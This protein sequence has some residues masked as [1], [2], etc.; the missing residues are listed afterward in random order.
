M[1]TRQAAA[2]LC[3]A[4]ILAACDR[5]SSDAD[6]TDWA[7]YMRGS[8]SGPC[9]VAEGRGTQTRWIFNDEVF[10]QIVT[11]S[12]N[13]NCTGPSQIETTTGGVSAAGDNPRAPAALDLFP[14]TTSVLPT[15]AEAAQALNDADTCKAVFAAG[16]RTA[17]N[18]EKCAQGTALF[19]APRYEFAQFIDRVMFFSKRTDSETGQSP[20]TR[21]RSIDPDV[22]YT[23]DP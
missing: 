14:G 22:I 15:T 12:P 1:P 9:L 13:E 11:R 4:A 21:P 2:G 23:K 18:P 6:S 10:V 17:V 3:L 19:T 5:D 16:S 8:W 7:S 20:E